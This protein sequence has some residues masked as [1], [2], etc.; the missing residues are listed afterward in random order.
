[1][2][3]DADG[4]QE[5]HNRAV[6]LY[7]SFDA[8]CLA[9]KNRLAGYQAQLLTLGFHTIGSVVPI[10]EAE[11]HHHTV[12]TCVILPFAFA[13][14]VI[15]VLIHRIILLYTGFD[16]ITTHNLGRPTT[17]LHL[18]GANAGLPLGPYLSTRDW[19]SQRLAV[20][21]AR[22]EQSLHFYRMATLASGL[23]AKDLES[24]EDNSVLCEGDLGII[25]LLIQH[26]PRVFPRHRSERTM[27]F[28]HNLSER[29]IMVDSDG[30]ITDILDWE[31]VCAVPF[32]YG[33][34]FPGVLMSMKQKLRPRRSEFG[35]AE[36]FYL[37]DPEE[38][39]DL[40]GVSL[41]YWESRERFEKTILRKVYMAEM[42]RLVPG[43]AAEYKR[44][45][46]QR[47]FEDCIAHLEWGG[48]YGLKGFED[49]LEAYDPVT[50][51]GSPEACEDRWPIFGEGLE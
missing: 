13:Y 34:Q 31:H 23:S 45:K 6:C 30:V 22:T 8:C 24:L 40:D 33:T 50:G 15:A 43:W 44:S 9:L 19:L 18:L 46:G 51:E 41:L 16:Y 5:G 14:A 39:G 47:E 21:Q 10:K 37:D 3:K 42:D 36:S 4:G 28:H 7:A 25:S 49:W 1:M 27:L 38:H 2:A 48:H 32:W 12:L 35:P 20:L 11:D 29:N 17:P 26:L